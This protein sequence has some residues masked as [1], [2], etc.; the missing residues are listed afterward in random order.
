MPARF[1]ELTEAPRLYGFHAT[2]KPPFRPAHPWRMLLDDVAQLAARLAPFDLPPLA[3]MDLGGFLALRETV[4]CPPLH[5][6]ADACVVELDTHREPPS[7]AELAQRRRG[8][9]TPQQDQML[10]D[11]GYPHVLGTW[12]FHMTLTRRL[13]PDE[14][15]AIQ[16]AA[17]AH[18]AAALAMPRRVTEIC[19]FTQAAAGAPFLLAERVALGG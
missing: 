6:L 1:D 16:P 19:L 14:R 18:F 4:A 8:G 5:A 2:L 7:A 17:A 9:L 11:W 3:V 10:L 12:R 13:S 15:A